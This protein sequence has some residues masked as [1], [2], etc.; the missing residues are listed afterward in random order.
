MQTAGMIQRK[1]ALPRIVRRYFSAYRTQTI[2]KPYSEKS[3]RRSAI[4]VPMSSGM[5][6]IPAEAAVA[7]AVSFSVVDTFSSIDAMMPE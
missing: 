6:V 4:G 3:A 2:R 1:T 5:A 7:D